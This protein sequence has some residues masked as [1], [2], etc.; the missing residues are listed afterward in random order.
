MCIG[1]RGELAGGIVGVNAR[2]RADCSE[3]AIRE[4]VRALRTEPAPDRRERGGAGAGTK[5]E[6]IVIHGQEGNR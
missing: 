1:K 6:N 5:D 2:N 3:I 4:V